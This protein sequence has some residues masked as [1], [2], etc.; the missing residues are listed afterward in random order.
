M[1]DK[2]LSINATEEQDLSNVTDYSFIN[3]YPTELPG[4]SLIHSRHSACEYNEHSYQQHGIVIHL[5]PE[6]NSLRRLGNLVEVENPTI[7]DIA[8]IP[9]NVNH[10]QRI[11]TE[12]AEG[13][14]LTIEPQVISHIAHETINPDKV[15]LLPVFAKPDPLIYGIAL[16]LKANL[17]S[18]SYDQLYTESLFNAF[19]LHLLRNYCTQPFQPESFKDGL[20]PY[21]LKQVLDLIGDRLGEEVS[22]SNMAKYLDLSTF[23]FVRQF[24]KSAGITPY[25][26][27]MQQRIEM[28]KGLLKQNKIS[29]A[30]V[31]LDCGFSNQS[32]LGRVFK[33]YTGATPKRYRQQIK[34]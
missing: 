15:E 9:A 33:R 26:Y 21:K 4:Q 25:Q 6:Q 8:I 5:K 10:W 27:V 30:D 1:S 18:G 29:I 23:H 2:Q 13:L 14:L 22:V 28:A 31:A 32:H 3:I 34:F 11:E 24:K 16:N 17:N 19:F 12:V 20:A 7:G